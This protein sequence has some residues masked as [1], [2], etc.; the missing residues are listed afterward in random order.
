LI[1]INWTWSGRC[2]TNSD[3]STKCI[4][5]EHDNIRVCFFDCWAVYD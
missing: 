2:T 4:K 3:C 1:I 5:W